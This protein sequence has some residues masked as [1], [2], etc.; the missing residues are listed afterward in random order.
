MPACC[1][2]KETQAML[3]RPFLRTGAF[4]FL[5]ATLPITGCHSQAASPTPEP[6]AVIISTLPEPGATAE[7]PTVLREEYRYESTLTTSEGETMP[8]EMNYIVD[9]PPGYQADGSQTYALVVHLHGAGTTGDDIER[10]RQLEQRPEALTEAAE[11]LPMILLYPQL[12][13]PYLTWRSIGGYVD[14]IIQTVVDAYPVDESRIYLSG[15]SDGGF[16]ALSIGALFP[17]R[18]AAV[19]SVAGYY[20]RDTADLCGLKGIPV[21]LYHGVMDPVVPVDESITVF[22]QLTTCDANATLILYNLADHNMVDWLVIE[23]LELY[24]WFYEHTKEL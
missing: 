2:K 23:D 21:R 9:L 14:A 4:I 8:F 7:T 12:P 1:L 22:N 13:T 16:G 24:R 20:A 17:E 11:E 5:A 3:D 19:A 15:Y 6:T 18:F 10:L